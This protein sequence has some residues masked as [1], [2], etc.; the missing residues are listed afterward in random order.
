MRKALPFIITAMVAAAVLFVL[1]KMRYGWYTSSS[2]AMFLN[3][4][5][6]V[7]I[8]AILSLWVYFP[9]R[10]GV[11]LAGISTLAFPTLLRPNVFAPLDVFFAIYAIIPIAL[12]VVATHLR[13]RARSSTN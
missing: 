1:F 5:F 8:A 3:V 6:C 7:G 9:T 10:A 4:G 2:E 11:A 13:L 12:L